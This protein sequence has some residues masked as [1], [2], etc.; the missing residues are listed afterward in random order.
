MKKTMLII[1]AFLMTVMVYSQRQELREASKQLNTKSFEQAK[2]TLAKIEGQINA[3]EAN[4]QA[5]YYLYKGQA[6][7]GATDNI[8]IEADKRVAD[9]VIASNAFRKVIEIESSGRQRHTKQA[10]ESMQNLLGGLVN[11]AIEDQTAERFSIASKKLYTGYTISKVD[12]VYLY[13]A[14]LNSISAEEYDNAMVYYEELLDLGYTGIEKEYVATDKESGDEVIF[15]DKKEQNLM[16]MSGAYL[17]PQERMSQSRKSDILKFLG[18]IYIEKGM[19]DEAK[20][21]IADARRADPN[22]VALI[23]AEA[24]IALQMDDMKTYNLLMQK[25]VESDPTNPDL[26]YNLGV[27]AASIGDFENA[28][29]YY[30]KAIELNP[31][32]YNAQVNLA[33]MILGQEE[34]IIEEMN[35]LGT[36]REDNRRY[37]A[38]IAQRNELYQEAIP[39]L[40]SASEGRPEDVNIMRTLMNI[41]YILGEDGKFNQMKNR[42][43]AIEN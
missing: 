8:N 41:Y 16:M 37:D 31:N 17:R 29:K 39:Y 26:F 36:S 34:S 23:Q 43:E 27:S 24:S 7:F 30:N 3:A 22:D 28:R 11:S 2:Q 1:T 19:L 35:N 6:Y 38:L 21:L 32:Y 14:A 9:L 20:T 40:E 18:L 33:V 25:V 13:F 10:E 5:E 12:T 4:T 42:M 15:A